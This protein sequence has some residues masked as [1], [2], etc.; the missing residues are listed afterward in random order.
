LTACQ[1]NSS[2]WHYFILFDPIWSLGTKGTSLYVSLGIADPKEVGEGLSLIRELSQSL[3]LRKNLCVP[4]I[5]KTVVLCFRTK[6]STAAPGNLLTAS[7]EGDT[8]S[9][10]DDGSDDESKNEPKDVAAALPSAHA[11]LSSDSATSVFVNPFQRAE[12]AKLS[13]LEKHVKLSI[14]DRSVKEIGGKKVCKN[15]RLG[16]CKQGHKCPNAHD[17]DIPV[18]NAEATS[19]TDYKGPSNCQNYGPPRN[20]FIERERPDDDN[21]MSGKPRKRRHGVTDN[22]QP[23]KKAMNNLNSLRNHERPWTVKK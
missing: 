12:E 22:L 18:A 6:P 13:V 10:S 9:D 1:L 3:F 4:V 2:R 21:Y 7:G 19:E 23:P 16:R 15:Y 11:V 8:S 5:N 17:G 20:L 14:I